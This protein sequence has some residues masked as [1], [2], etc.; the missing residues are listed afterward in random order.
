[1]QVFFY[2]CS[3]IGLL[4]S[5]VF[6]VSGDLGNATYIAVLSVLLRMPVSS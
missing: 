4:V 2:V 3:L 6:A 5:I 1:M